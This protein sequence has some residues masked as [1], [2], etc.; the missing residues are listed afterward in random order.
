L[1]SI[2]DG[3]PRMFTSEAASALKIVADASIDE[4]ISDHVGQ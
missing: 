3:W 1:Q 2:V 4:L